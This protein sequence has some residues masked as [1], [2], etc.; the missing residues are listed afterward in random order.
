[1]FTSDWLYI[2]FS[3][4]VIGVW[5]LAYQQKKSEV[6]RLLDDFKSEIEFKERTERVAGKLEMIERIK[7]SIS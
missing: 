6:I 7:R 2:L 3:V 1:M 4:V 5:M